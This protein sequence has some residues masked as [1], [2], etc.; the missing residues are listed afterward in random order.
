MAIQGVALLPTKW[1]S[2]LIIRPQAL[3]AGSIILF[4]GAATLLAGQ[5][6]ETRSKS[7]V[8]LPDPSQDF[9]TVTNRPLA[10]VYSAMIFP[11]AWH[12]DD[13]VW[14]AVEKPARLPGAQR[15]GQAGQA[16]LLLRCSKRSGA[17]APGDNRCPE[18]AA[19]NKKN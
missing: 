6:W 1:E 10:G 13:A 7:A 4:T 8:A 3:A 19:I 5:C 14:N 16:L 11:R 2:R 18:Q 15:T 9:H 12:R 17:G